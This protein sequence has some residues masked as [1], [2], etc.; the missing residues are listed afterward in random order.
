MTGIVP[1]PTEASTSIW[2]NG[3][4]APAGT[5]GR[6]GWIRLA[7][8]LFNGPVVWAVHLVAGIALVPASCAHGVGWTINVL[9]VF[10]AVAIAVVM[11]DAWRLLT[12]HRPD[13]PSA[14]PVIAVIATLGLLWGAISLLVTVL[15]GIP[16]LVLNACPI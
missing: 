3:V 5:E 14:D 11:V 8:V 12:R 6:P 4:P 16:N 15:E 13:G 9:T 2:T 10:S 1:P 7:V